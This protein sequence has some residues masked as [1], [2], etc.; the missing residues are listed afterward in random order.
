[1]AWFRWATIGGIFLIIV[2]TPFFLFENQIN[3]FVERLARSDFR[4]EAIALAVI[5]LLA[6]DVFLPV[7]SSIVST[8]A[9]ATLGFF[10]GLIAS[11]T[12]MTFG[13]VLAYICGRAWGLPLVRRLTGDRDLEIVSQR[14][15]R[16]AGWAL[17]AMRPVPVL[18]EASVLF[19]GVSRLPFPGYLAITTLANTGISA[20]YCAAGARALASGSF[21]LAFAASL[22]LPG[23]A[24]LIGRLIRSGR[25]R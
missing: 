7:P 12:G 1:M 5:C 22:A 20:V 10:P 4:I 6:V 24:I 16:S 2:L 8:V 18:A 25:L 23:V 14:F 17:A 9:G 3:D 13:C 19:A 11:S 15:R 21:L